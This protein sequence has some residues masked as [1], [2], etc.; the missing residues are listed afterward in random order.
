MFVVHK[1]MGISCFLTQSEDMT[2]VSKPTTLQTVKE[3]SEVT[4]GDGLTL[5]R[6][7]SS[8]EKLHIIVGYA[9]VRRDLRLMQSHFEGIYSC[10]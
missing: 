10:C 1:L 2:E 4:D 3:N 9:I 7:L 8:L 5:D 6:P